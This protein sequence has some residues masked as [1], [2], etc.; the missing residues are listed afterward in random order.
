MKYQL[1]LNE[2]QLE[3]INKALDFY[4]RMAAGQFGELLSWFSG[5]NWVKSPDAEDRE[6]LEWLKE[7]LTGLRRNAYRSI[8]TCPEPA[9]IAYD[10]YQVIRNR[11][12]W[13]RNPKGGIQVSYDDPHQVSAETLPEIEMSEL[14]KL[15]LSVRRIWGNEGGYH[16]QLDQLSDCARQMADLILDGKYEG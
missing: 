4:S 11:L 1:T 6:S 3:V 12:A 2:R 8:V 9:R 15:A 16:D 10:I 7:R 13:D 14:G 5:F